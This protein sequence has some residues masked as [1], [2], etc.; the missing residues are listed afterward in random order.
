MYEYVELIC[1][2][3]RAFAISSTSMRTLRPPPAKARRLI[4]AE[5]ADREP[6]MA[7][8]GYLTFSQL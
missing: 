4:I 3:L 8:I 6:Y 2:A 7:R 5:V 1:A